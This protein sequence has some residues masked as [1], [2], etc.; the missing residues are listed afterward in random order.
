MRDM[1]KILNKEP[2]KLNLTLVKLDD[3]T[4]REIHQ[5]VKLI[6][7]SLDKNND[8]NF[9]VETEEEVV[10][11]EDY[12]NMLEFPVQEKKLFAS[13]IFTGDK[14]KTYSFI[15]FIL[16]NFKKLEKRAYLGY[17]LMPID[18]PDEFI[19]DK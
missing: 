12:L 16:Q 10:K 2:F 5:L 3:Y 7:D 8:I 1:V 17:Y 18:I 4:V 6:L 15:Y 11:F 13:Q 14:N 19:I 9:T